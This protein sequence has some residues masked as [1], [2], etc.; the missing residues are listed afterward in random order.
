DAAIRIV[1]DEEV[2][3]VA[4]DVGRTVAFENV[5]VDP[6]AVNVVHEQSAV[7]FFRVGASLIDKTSRVGVTATALQTAR[8][9]VAG[10]RRHAEV[11]DVVADLPD[12]AVGVG[13]EVL[14]RLPDVQAAGDH[15]E[16]VR[17]DTG[18]QEAGAVLIEVEPPRVTGA[19]SEDLELLRERVV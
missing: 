11:V 8:V 10:V 9:L 17:D 16:Q 7:P 2:G 1:G 13:V 4:A 3:P 12:V 15:V 5:R 19:F 6:A 18:G 14:P